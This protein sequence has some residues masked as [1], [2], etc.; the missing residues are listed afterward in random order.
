MANGGGG[1]V[2]DRAWRY[3]RAAS[4][5][6]GPRVFPGSLLMMRTVLLGC[7]GWG[8]V[9]A[10]TIRPDDLTVLMAADAVHKGSVKTI[11]MGP[12]K[13]GW[14]ESWDSAGSL[15]WTGKTTVPGSYTLFA[16]LQGSGSGCAVE[17]AINSRRLTA[18][19]LNT[20]WERVKLG[21]VELSA[22]I[23]RFTFRSVG[24]SPVAKVFSL[25]IV[26]PEVQVKLAAQAALG[27]APTDWMVQAKYGVMVHWTSQSKPEQ[28]RPLAYC[29]AVRGFDVQKFADMLDEMG[30][31]Y[32]VFTTSHAEFYFPGPSTVI[33]EILPGRTCSRDLVGDLAQALSKHG[34]KLELY[35]HPGHDDIEW[36]RRTHFDDDKDKYFELWCRVIG[37]IGGHYGLSIAGY[38]FDD[39][40][41]T[42]YPFNAPWAKMATASKQGNPDRLV[43][44]N[45]WILPKV[46]DFYEVFA[47]ENDFSTEMINGF[48]FLPV[49]GTGKFTG[50]PQSGLQGQITTII[51][52]DWGHFKLDTP[53]LP[54]RYSLD[55]MIARIRDAISRRNVPTFDVEV[56]QDGRISPETLA[57]FKEIRRAIKP[58]KGE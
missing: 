6:L 26:K 2:L 27:A 10:Q 20:D 36:W 22:P 56:Y 32:V 49:D 47:G 12:G 55:T 3:C 46:S 38:W 57:L 7:L 24:P 35:F 29:Q 39:A 25:E 4:G 18:S 34:I 33:D 17:V 19:C 30:A 31:G 13:V 28:G 23:Q 9:H 42:Y 15:S 48:G 40:A 44:Y 1:H 41:F 37:Q 50:G 8:T 52:G 21:T 16:I 43:A 54:P 53:I 45:S 14:V 51:N 5:C 11:N 58:T